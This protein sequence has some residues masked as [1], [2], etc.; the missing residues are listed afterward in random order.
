M[1]NLF[2]R[3]FTSVH[4]SQELLA[5][6]GTQEGQFKISLNVPTAVATLEVPAVDL[7][8]WRAL[9]AKIFNL[10]VNE[11]DLNLSS[12]T[13]S[14]FDG[15]EIT[16]IGFESFPLA[17]FGPTFKLKVLNNKATIKYR[18]FSY[19]M[20]DP[21]ISSV[22][23]ENKARTKYYV[24]PTYFSFLKR[25]LSNSFIKGMALI[26]KPGTGKSTDAI[27]VVNALGGICLTKQLSAGL[28]ENDLFT[29]VKPNGMLTKFTEKIA[30]G[31][32]LTEDEQKIYDELVKSNSSFIEVDEIIM[33]GIKKNCPVLLDETAYANAAVLS[34]FN[35]LTDGTMSFYHNGESHKIPSNFFL[36]FTWNPGDEGTN[37]IPNALKTRFL[38]H[39]VPPIDKK[40]HQERMQSFAKSELGMDEINPVFLDALFTF[41][42]KVEQDQQKMKH[43]GGSFT[44]RATQMLCSTIFDKRLSRKEFMLELKSKFVNP[45]WGTNYE[46]TLAIEDTISSVEYKPMLDTIYKYYESATSSLALSGSKVKLP[47]C[48]TLFEKASDDDI[49]VEGITDPLDSLDEFFGK[50]DAE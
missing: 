23:E 32:G 24:E 35:V 29:N 6:L 45:L 44:L 43:N 11:A 3:I 4:D 10:Y 12:G 8:K 41:G 28:M 34:K 22:Y 50:D 9:V 25:N 14:E 49:F 18:N 33:L 37:D 13:I 27:A 36:F 47:S 46:N 38:V 2:V 42:N 19:D 20:T 30:S 1:P 40:T 17:D 7:K 5:I 21:F 31:V 39:I 26:G 15:V 48:S 16:T